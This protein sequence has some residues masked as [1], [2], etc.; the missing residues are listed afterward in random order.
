MDQPRP[1]V[2]LFSV[3]SKKQYNV[4]NKSMWNNV[5]LVYRAGIWTYD[6]SLDQGSST[7]SQIMMF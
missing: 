6:L 4:Y 2:N 5:Y 3:F 7:F 1:L